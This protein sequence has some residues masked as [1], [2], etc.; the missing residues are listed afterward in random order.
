MIRMRAGPTCPRVCLKTVSW[1]A[2]LIILPPPILVGERS[3]VARKVPR[4]TRRSGAVSFEYYRHGSLLL[5]TPRTLML[6]YTR[7]RMTAAQLL[8]GEGESVFL[9]NI[10]YKPH[11]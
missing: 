8:G 10:T 1:V 11:V 9:P 3:G 5:G 7:I 6:E 2:R 4:T